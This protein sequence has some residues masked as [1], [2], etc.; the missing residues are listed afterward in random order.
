M[1][2]RNVLAVMPTGS[3]KS[4]CYQVPALAL[5][6]LTIVV[7]PLVS[8]MQDQVKALKAVGVRAETINAT[9]TRSEN[10]SIWRRVEMGQVELLYL[11][12][13]RL[14]ATQMITA[15]REM[16]VRLIAVDEAHCISHWGQSFRPEYDAL[17]NLRHEFPGLPIGAFTATANAA[18]RADIT[19]KLLGGVADEYVAGFDR[20]NIHLAV[21]AK[22]QS[23][24]QILDFLGQHSEECGIIYSLSRKSTEE[25][26]EFLL[27]KGYRALPYHAGLSAEERLQNQNI[28]MAKP[29]VII[30]ATIAFGMGIDKPNV[31]FVVHAD[32]PSSLD[33][34]YQ[35]IGRAGRDGKP[36]FAI[37]YFGWKDLRVRRQFIDE[38]D[39][40]EIQRQREHQRLDALVTYCQVASCR[41]KALLVYFG[42]T[43]EACGNCDVCN[44][45]GTKI[46]QTQAL[47]SVRK[48][49]AFFPFSLR[50]RTKKNR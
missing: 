9:L 23:A 38:V 33:S 34:Y 49:A 25:W 2:G 18:T 21:E 48:F 1:A 10:I 30:C 16:E 3:G 12:P 41:R 31:R 24:N 42:E 6:G 50:R 40:V 27:A 26:A 43:V 8:L 28:F 46:W 13:E 44:D 19:K 4:L 22:L 45:L 39:H 29:G 14:M 5:G 15:L 7:S 20:P 36:A 47:N 35:E 11:A 37:M 32:M 17:Q